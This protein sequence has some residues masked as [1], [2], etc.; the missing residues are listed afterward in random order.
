MAL[1]VSLISA[2]CSFGNVTLQSAMFQASPKSVVGVST[3]LFQTCRHIGSIL[4]AVSLGLVFGDHFSPENFTILILVFI[5]AD[6]VIVL[7]GVRHSKLNPKITPSKMGLF[8][9]CL[10]LH[11]Q[12]I[13]RFSRKIVMFFI[14]PI[15]GVTM[16]NTFRIFEVL[17][18]LYI[19]LMLR[20]K[21]GNILIL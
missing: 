21:K 16:V 19:V 7:L 5:A 20:L 10:L 8:V 6:V 3:G 1:I 15:S 9:V 13:H 18:I 17:P 4:S 12:R 11:I 2:G 14:K